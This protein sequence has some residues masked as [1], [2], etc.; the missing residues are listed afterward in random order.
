MPGKSCACV[1]ARQHCIGIAS[2][3]AIQWFERGAAGMVFQEIADGIIGR[4]MTD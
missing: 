3:V 2:P 1:H 4:F